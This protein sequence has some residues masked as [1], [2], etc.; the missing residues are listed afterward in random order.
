MLETAAGI[1]TGDLFTLI[2]YFAV[3]LWIAYLCSRRLTTTDGFFVGARRI[4]GWAV[5]I[6]MIGT[7]I[8]SVTFL[9]YPADAFA[10]DW[11]NLVPGLTIPVA[12]IM[13][14]Y[15][16]VP[17]YRRMKLVSAYEYLERRYAPWARAY[18]CV[19]WAL[20]QLYRMGLVLLLVSMVAHVITGWDTNMIILIM[21]A[22]VIVY[23]ILGGIEA[24]IW[25]DVMQTIVLVLGGLICILV[26][27]L[28]VPDGAGALL[29]QAWAADKFAMT[30]TWELDFA[31]T[32]IWVL[33][34]FGLTQNLQEFVSDQTRIQRYCAA[35]T[36]RGA[37]RAVWLGGLG[38]IPVWAL[39][40]LVGTC[41]WGFYG[42]YPERLAE[43]LES[44]QIFPYFILNELPIG[45]AGFVI[46]AV[47][48][49]AMSSIDS[50]LNGTATVLTSDIYRRFLRKGL[51][52]LHYLF[53]ARLATGVIG[54]I[55]I[56]CAWGLHW[57]LATGILEHSTILGLA[58]F[59]YAVLAG[60]VA[61]LFFLGFFTTRA[62]NAG[63][64]VGIILAVLA[65]LYLTFSDLALLPET[66]RS[67]T[68]RLLIG[69]IS[70]T[71]SFVVGYLVSLIY[72]APAMERLA[73]LTVWTWE[74]KE[75][76]L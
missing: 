1:R 65:T 30:V 12:V 3:T 72:P 68:H 28:Q 46:A 71:L 55:V 32:T 27:F 11:R 40:M 67:P 24:V 59:F 15:L 50:S 2:L 17:Y 54:A 56:L 39:F 36:D 51:N 38:C 21:G 76:D 23:T 45:I 57:V 60:G 75:G 69:F 66:M 37:I 5:G 29:S 19:V 41:L 10:E 49:A 25:T 22:L 34:L 74:K 4:P 62:N 14:V 16:F 63:A 31:R 8:S 44:A 73:N 7:A 47:L 61:G 6:S 52:D 70:N 53:M 26:V 35:S 20:I 42:L 13:A 48:A 43:G 64:I 33:I 58:F 9:A 18:G